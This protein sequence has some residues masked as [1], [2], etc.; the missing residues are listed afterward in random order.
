MIIQAVFYNNPDGYPPIINSARLLA[1]AGYQIDIL[2][3]EYGPEWSIQYPA[4]ATVRRLPE[5][6]RRTWA[7]YLAFVGQVWRRVQPEAAVFVG[8]DMHGF[9]PA[10]LL[11]SR[12]RRPLIYHCHDFALEHDRMAW[13]GRLVAAF[14]RR[15]ART[16][17]L[18]I[19]PDA[20]RGEAIRQA[21]RLRQPPMIVANAPLQAP[22]PSD[23]LRQHLQAQGYSWRR[24]VLRQ[25]QVGPGHAL[26]ATIRSLPYW[27]SAD[28]GIAVLGSGESDFK[29]HLQRLAV[30]LNVQSQLAFLPPVAY[31]EVAELTVGADVGHALYD[32]INLNHQTATTSSNKIME[33][34]AANLPLLVSDRPGLRDLVS[35]YQCGIVANESDPLSIAGAIN[36][37]LANPQEA[38]DMG[39][40]GRQAFAEIFCYEKQFAPVL[41]WLQEQGDR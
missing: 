16:A 27:Q 40:K 1:Q 3:R 36:Q 21:L 18:V 23:R 5:T 14:E 10:R 24:I 20:E 2:C 13:G 6:T 4:A 30:G 15:W 35:R 17:D 9:L 33:Y 28:W 38:Q 25:G 19:V 39:N 31:D 12:Y 8:H 26:E 37:L 11:A 22:P 29:L 7:A 32:P 41:A 34:M